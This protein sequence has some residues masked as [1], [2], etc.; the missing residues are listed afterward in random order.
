MAARGVGGREGKGTEGAQEGRRAGS[1][2]GRRAEVSN[3]QGQHRTTSIG[4]PFPVLPHGPP[5]CARSALTHHP[6]QPPHSRAPQACRGLQ[7]LPPH[8]PPNDSGCL[9]RA[10]ARSAAPKER[11]LRR[12]RRPPSWP[13][14]RA[15]PLEPA[16]AAEGQRA[17]GGVS[18]CVGCGGAQPWRAAKH[19][20]PAA[21]M[22]CGRQEACTGCCASAVWL[23]RGWRH[24]ALTAFVT[25]SPSLLASPCSSTLLKF[26]SPI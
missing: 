26:R 6:P 7:Q 17:L 20:I 11:C 22:A 18:G 25:A 19:G 5:Q 1:T 10:A 16:S 8:A 14:P 12:R 9:A 4:L 23:L 21:S 2:G 24:V 3:R 15:S 13:A